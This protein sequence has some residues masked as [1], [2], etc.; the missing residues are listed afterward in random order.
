MVTSG[1]VGEVALPVEVGGEPTGGGGGNPAAAAAEFSRLW[2]SSNFGRDKPASREWNGVA[3][4]LYPV[5]VKGVK[6]G[7]R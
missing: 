5:V 6:R 4:K 7:C 3:A 1:E 2:Y